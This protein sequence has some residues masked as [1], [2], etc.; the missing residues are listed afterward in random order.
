MCTKINFFLQIPH[1][2]YSHRTHLTN[3]NTT[4]QIIK[5]LGVTLQVGASYMSTYNINFA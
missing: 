2:L 3:S 4:T 5:I 1:V